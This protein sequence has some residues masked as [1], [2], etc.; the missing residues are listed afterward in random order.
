MYTLYAAAD[1]DVGS[2]GDARR[3]ARVR[4][5]R[6]RA[7]A[8][9]SLVRATRE[10]ASSSRL[11]APPA[12]PESSFIHILIASYKHNTSAARCDTI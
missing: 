7:R 12:A 11:S 3:R 9:R 10:R 4:P 6:E 1:G 8:G 2:E 5:T